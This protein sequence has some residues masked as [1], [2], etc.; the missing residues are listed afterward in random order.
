VPLQAVIDALVVDATAK[1]DAKVASGDLSA[2]RAA[3]IK[4]NLTGRITALSTLKALRKQ[5]AHSEQEG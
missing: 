4:A 1:I 5:R 3:A 2:E